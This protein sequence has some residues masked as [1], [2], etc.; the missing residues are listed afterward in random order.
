MLKGKGISEGIG[1][2]KAV[3][4]KNEEK[5]PVAKAAGFFVVRWAW[6]V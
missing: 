4:L 5:K 3:I 6:F 2:V 1:L